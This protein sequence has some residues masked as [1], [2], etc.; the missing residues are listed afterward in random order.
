[1]RY[2]LK[3]Y[4]VTVFLLS[5]IF[6]IIY[7]NNDSFADAKAQKLWRYYPQFSSCRGFVVQDSILWGASKN[8]GVF[9]LN[10]NED[11]YEW[12]GFQNGLLDDN[13]HNISLA[14]DGT[15]WI[16]TLSGLNSYKDGK[17][18]SYTI[19]GEY[20]IS[21]ALD[22]VA[23][24]S[25]NVWVATYDRTNGK[26]GLLRFDGEKWTD[27]TTEVIKSDGYR[28]WG[29]AIDTRGD[30]WCCPELGSLSRYDGE[31]WI[32]YPYN[33]NSNQGYRCL[34][35]DKKGNLWF[36]SDT[37][38]YK[39]DGANFTRY[40]LPA[41][42][43][44]AIYRSGDSRYRI[45]YEI[46]ID[47]NGSVWCTTTSGIVVLKDGQWYEGPH[48]FYT[49]SLA[50]DNEDHLWVSLYIEGGVYGYYLPI[51]LIPVSVEDIKEKPVPYIVD[52][53]YPNPFNPVTTISYYVPSL[54][55]VS[56]NVYNLAGQKVASLVDGFINVGKHEIAFHGSGLSSG[57]YLY[58][59]N[60]EGFR[61][62]GKMLLMK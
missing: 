41:P 29:I 22:A 57:V 39:Y 52:A 59:F 47:G 49:F 5:I 58:R 62:T 30:V 37:S 60:A 55:Y 23:D 1:M 8:Y 28:I 20:L 15:L 36:G 25:G 33:V 42:P 7:S 19:A 48:D 16:S 51:D 12:F 24:S 6:L 38:L 46:A 53:P 50:V 40:G 45:I 9:R 43:D 13:V 35:A 54:D 34:L 61:K 14:K 18:K 56:L 4:K 2:L 26:G 31:K 21:C 3:I 44:D 17:F 27:F 32:T 10:I 11:T